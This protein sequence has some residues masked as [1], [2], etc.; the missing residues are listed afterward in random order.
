M[1]GGAFLSSLFSG[2]L[3]GFLADRWLGTEPWLVV[4]GIILGSY[5]GFIRL[6]RFLKDQD[7]DRH[8]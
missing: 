3:L 1:Q 8:V 2:T 5:A 4:T 6:W 7:G